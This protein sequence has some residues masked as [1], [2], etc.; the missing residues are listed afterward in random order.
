[1]TTKNSKQEDIIEQ[2]LTD[3]KPIKKCIKVMKDFDETN[4]DRRKAFEEFAAYLVPH[5][6]AEEHVLYAFLKN[7]ADL[8]Q[9]GFEGDVEHDLAV[10]L[11]D[12]IKHTDDEDLWSAKVKVLAELVEHH[13]K[14][15]EDE[16]LPNFKKHSKH[17]ER[18]YLG[19]DYAQAKNEIQGQQR[20]ETS[21][22]PEAVH[23][24]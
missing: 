4:N 1:M 20:P 7:D 6:K 13:L 19:Q 18:I 15:E 11:I 3:H 16:V 22:G 24:Q 9:E 5:A 8:C 23:F 12:D 2:I 10:N 17:D 14:E 21:R